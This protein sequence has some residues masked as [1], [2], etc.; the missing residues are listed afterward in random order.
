MRF[1]GLS[2]TFTIYMKV[3]SSQ[4]TLLQE[5]TGVSTILF[6]TTSLTAANYK[7]IQYLLHV[8]KLGP[9]PIVM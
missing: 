1:A 3:K 9:F 7:A 4:S 8:L 2:C 6:C 5:L